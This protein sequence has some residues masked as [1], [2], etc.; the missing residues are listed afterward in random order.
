MGAGVPIISHAR[1][2]SASAAFGD[3]TCAT[4]PGQPRCKRLRGISF[5]G[6]ASYDACHGL[7][8]GLGRQAQRLVTEVD[9]FL[10][11]VSAEEQLIAG[12]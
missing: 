9:L 1:S 12:Q 6:E 5:L 8:C 11:D 4:N 7:G 2:M 10:A 3:G